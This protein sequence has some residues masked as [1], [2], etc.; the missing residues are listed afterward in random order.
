MFV[1]CTDCDVCKN[2]VDKNEYSSLRWKRNVD[3]YLICGAC[4]E[5]LECEPICENCFCRFC[6]VSIDEYCSC[7]E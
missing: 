5:K 6:Y 2:E 4:R 3:G 7:Y 1:R